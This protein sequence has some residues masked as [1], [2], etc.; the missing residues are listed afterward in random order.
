MKLGVWSR[1]GIVASALWAIT[2]PFVVLGDSI[3][4]C[5]EGTSW[6]CDYIVGGLGV[7]PLGFGVGSALGLSNAGIWGNVVWVSLALPALAWLVALAAIATVKW[8]AA[9]KRQREN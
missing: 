5:V 3:R 9:G 2:A 1:L 7:P 6:G 8:V 4:Q